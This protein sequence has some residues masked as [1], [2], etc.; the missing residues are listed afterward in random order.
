MV[1]KVIYDSKEFET[2]EIEDVIN[3]IRATSDNAEFD[4][5]EEIV[6]KISVQD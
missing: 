2:E 3:E 5:H 1:Y 4:G 6:I